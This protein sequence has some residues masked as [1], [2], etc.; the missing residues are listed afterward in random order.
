MKLKKMEIENYR[1][2]QDAVINFDDELTVLAG[3][4]NSGKT[5]IIELFR[6]VFK[7]KNFSKEDVAAEFYSKLQDDFLNLI[8]KI[9]EE[10]WDETEFR[11]NVK[12]A[13]STQKEDKWTAI[14]IK[15]EVT[16][17]KD[18]SIS[19]FSDYLME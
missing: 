4:N 19:L 6:R 1:Q 18:E 17:N 16:Y 8:D 2:F 5:S 7:D 14:R 9:Y 10:S 13:F 11:E 15:I 3:A 12:K